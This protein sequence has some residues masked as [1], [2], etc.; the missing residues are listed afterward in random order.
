MNKQYGSIKTAGVFLLA[1]L[2]LSATLYAQVGTEGAILGVVTDS[3]GAVVAGAEVTVVNLGTNLTKKATSDSQGNFEILALPRGTYSI[4]AAFS[5]FKTWVVEKT[6][7]TLGERKRVSPVLT[8]GEISDKVT[9]EA[10]AEVIQTEKGSLESVVA[11]KTI[12]ELPLNGRNPVELVRLIPGMRYL[13]QGGPERGITVQGLGNRTGDGGGTE[14]QV[15]GLNANAGMDEGGFG[16]PNVDT[17]AEFNVETANFSAEHGRNALQVLSVTKSG[18]NGI[19]GTL[20]E[21]HRN[22]KMDARNAF[23]LTKPKLIRNQYGYSVGGPVIKDKTFFFT[24]YEG[25]KIRTDKIYNSTPVPTAFF[26][27]DFSALSKQIKDPLTGQPFAGNIIPANRIVSSAK[28]FFPYILTPNSGDGRYRTVASQPQDIYEVTARIDHQLTNK[29]RIYGRYIINNSDQSLPQYR[30]DVT[31]EN[32]TKQQ[33][34]GLNYTYAVTPTTLFTLGGNYLRSLNLFTTPVAGTTNL[35]E[36]AGIQGFPTAGRDEFIGLPTINFTGYESIG[37]PWGT[38]GRLWFESQSGKASANLIRGTHS[39]N[40]GYEY[41]N[42]TTY[43]RHGSCCSRGVFGFNGQYT[44]DGFADYLLGLI[45]NSQR[46]YPIQTFGMHT[47]PYHGLYVQ[48]FWKLSPN[49]TVNLGLRWDYWGEKAAVRGNVGSFDLASG[50][51]VAG[52]DTNGKVDLTSQPVAPYLAAATAG[53]WV[54]ASQIGAPPGLFEGNGYLSPR[55]GI[56]WR[57]RGNSDFVVR[58]GYGI[59]TSSFTGN[60]TASSIVAPPYWTFES[61]SWSAASLQRWETAWPANPQSFVTPSVVAPSIKMKSN[62]SHQMN[63]SVQKSFW[64]DSAI[65]A[66]YVM[67]RTLDVFDSPAMS[68]FN[69]VRP[70]AYTNI[71]AAKPY[72]VFGDVTLYGND[73]DSYYNSGQLKW[74]KRF[75]KGLS[76]LLSYAFSK[77]IDDKVAPTPF[78]P[79]GYDRGRST[80]DRTHILA[81]NGIYELPF[82]KGRQYLTN[83]HPVANAILGGWQVA[84]IYNFTSG[85]PLT[86][87]A[88]GATLGNG[89]NSRA[90]LSGDPKLSDPTAARWFNPQAFATPANYTFGN[91]GR[92][93]IDGPGIH[94]MDTSLT[95]NFYVTESKYVQFRWEMFNMPN[96]VNLNNPGGSSTSQTTGLDQT[97]GLAT[98]GLITSAGSARSMQFGLKFVF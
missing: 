16:I 46:N 87:Y 45:Q 98:T 14:F 79:E 70:G 55:L 75:S 15:D 47:S 8:V 37:A 31:Q 67:N 56:A 41:D 59:F 34:V 58:A 9:V 90:N 26:N 85:A 17:I 84:G 78:A 69:T 42:R 95:K 94:A 73:G 96:H 5:G 88:P 28:F 33:N 50:K 80:F 19:H 36:Q 74:E 65:T 76:Y 86:F 89:F 82:G 3:S 38:P 51:A 62:K 24:S 18:T 2:A 77:H 35:T 71:Q 66:S 10:T 22:A 32:G 97:I 49:L 20:W 11:Q 72:P 12:V 4:T 48:D 30:P 81:V 52:E 53:Q 23:A 27:G 6:E 44:N 92:G 21:F 39:L 29:Q 13:G 40:I 7:L 83:M 93:I 57:P 43:G 61:T 60:R 54:P 1:F 63:V 91:S 64:G 25:T 68:G